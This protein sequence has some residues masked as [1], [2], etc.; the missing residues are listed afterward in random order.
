MHQKNI[1]T[2]GK[3]LTATSKVLIMLHGRGGS[4]EDILSFSAHLNVKDF[5]L[6]A[7]EATDN[8]WYPYSFLAPPSQN[9][10]WLSSAL[11]LIEELVHEVL[12]KGVTTENIYFCGFSQGACLI[13][14]YVTRN[15][16][17]YGGIAAFTG[18]L[19]GD[20]IYSENYKGDFQGTPVFIGTSNPDPHVP[21]ERVY[22]TINILK[23]MNAVVTEKVYNNMGH[24]I[25]QDE[26]DNANKLVFNAQPVNL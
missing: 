8:T 17:K 12:S 14:E 23:D 15:A 11:K 2:K 20:K 19:I 24:T 3:E 13:L 18:G 21:V 7:P 16:N 5:T 9:E 26:I 25:N 22:A 10:P 1:V 6:F 4:A